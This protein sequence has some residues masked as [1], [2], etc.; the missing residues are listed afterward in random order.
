MKRLIRLLLLFFL[1]PVFALLSIVI[2]DLLVENYTSDKVYDELANLPENRVGLLLGTNR[3][4]NS[5]TIN[6]YYKYRIDAAADL[7]KSGKI[8]YILASGDNSRVGYDEPEMMRED[9]MAKGVP[10]SK[11]FLDY[12]GFRTLDSVVRAKEIFGQSSITFISQQF[13]NERAICIAAYKG[14]DAVGY[15]ARGVSLRSGIRVVIRERLA[16]VKMVLDLL[17]GKG[18]KFLGDPI[19]IA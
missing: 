2:A 16:R 12:A 10:S 14:M 3:Y 9:L 7:Y 5:G 15:N 19:E 18:P 11:I 6:R 13:H 17:I 8:S 1:I 4:M